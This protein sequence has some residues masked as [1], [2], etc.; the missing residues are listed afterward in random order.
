MARPLA[1]P[2]PEPAPTDHDPRAEAPAYLVEDNRQVQYF[3]DRFTGSRR[4]VVG[5]WLGRAGGY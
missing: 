1:I 4:E 5:R 2:E 3:H